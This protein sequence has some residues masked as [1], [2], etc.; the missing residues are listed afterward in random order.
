MFYKKKKKEGSKIPKV[1]KE[2]DY[3]AK[4]DREFSLFI[5]SSYLLEDLLLHETIRAKS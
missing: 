3:K 1:K 4:L 5:Q 2:P